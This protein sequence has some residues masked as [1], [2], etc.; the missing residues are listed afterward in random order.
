M[1][2]GTIVSGS[3]GNSVYVGD[4][5]TNILVD[6]GVSTKRVV[7]GLT[8]YG[9]DPATLNGIFIT[10]EHSDHIQGL[11]VFSRK[12]NIPIYATKGTIKGIVS[13]K[14][15]GNFDKELLNE[16]RTDDNISIGDIT[17][18]PFKVSHDANEPC[19][20]TF[21][22]GRDKVAVATDMG[23]FDDYIINNLRG[24]DSLVLEANHDIN[25]LMVGSYPYYLKQRILGNK[26]HLSNE[27]CGRLLNKILHDDFKGVILGHLSKENNYPELAYETVK[28]EISLGP[29]QYK[30]SDFPIYVAPRSENSKMFEI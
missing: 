2:I 12:Y 3:S 14:S 21:S 23:I 19:A 6:I 10:H 5:D 25:M 9:V 29:G 11:G 15:L 28:A 8:D 30:G 13:S 20:Y 4:R 1:R 26:G 22:N 16:I 27:N 17:A 7:A 24:V 18:R